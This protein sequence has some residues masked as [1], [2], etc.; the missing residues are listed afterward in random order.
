[1]SI[2]DSFTS[3][4]TLKTEKPHFFRLLF[5]RLGANVVVCLM[6]IFYFSDVFV[7]DSEVGSHKI[8][9]TRDGAAVSELAIAV[10]GK[11]LVQLKSIY[12]Q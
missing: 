12:C 11:I 2:Q 9:Q 1:M 8:N 5:P 6:N 10:C 7:D 3:A 4:A